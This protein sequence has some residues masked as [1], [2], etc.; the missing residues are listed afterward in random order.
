[1]IFVGK[2]YNCRLL[3]NIFETNH[4]VTYHQFTYLSDSDQDW[5][6]WSRGIPVICRVTDK[7]H[8]QLYQVDGFYIEVKTETSAQRITTTRHFE[9]IDELD[10]YLSH[11]NISSLFAI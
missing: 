9:E 11:V 2:K 10:I 1:L 3:S 4:H 6:L 7:Y 8:Y 5:I